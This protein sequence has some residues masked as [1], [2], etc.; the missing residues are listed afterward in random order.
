MEWLSIITGFAGVVLGSSVMF[1]RQN[2]AAK[3]IE[4]ETNLSKEWERLYIEKKNENK[5][6]QNEITQLRHHLY[7]VEAK[8]AELQIKLLTYEKKQ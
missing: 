1:Y 3:I 6:L 5:E 2:K 7:E 4:N 8:V